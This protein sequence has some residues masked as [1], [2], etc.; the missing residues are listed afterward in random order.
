MDWMKRIKVVMDVDDGSF[1]LNP[2]HCHPYVPVSVW[3]NACCP[4]A[5]YSACIFLSS[6]A[7]ISSPMQRKE[8]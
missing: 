3:S 6:S 7:Q 4:A 8:Y 5:H 2:V 1:D